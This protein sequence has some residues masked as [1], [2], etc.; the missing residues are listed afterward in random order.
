MVE[1]VQAGIKVQR[2]AEFG[3]LRSTVERAL[4]PDTV[5]SFLRQLK[6]KGLRV[7]QWEAV[8][9][10]KVFE[11]VDRGLAAS[12]QTAADLFRGLPASDQGQVREFYLTEIEKIAPPLRARYHTQFE[13]F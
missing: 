6:R 5:E 2:E 10:A 7:R 11:A 3:R 1:F 13:T 4:G 9:E 12:G 8:L